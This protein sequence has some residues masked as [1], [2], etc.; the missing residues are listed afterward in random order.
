MSERKYLVSGQQVEIERRLDEGFLV[1]KIFVVESMEFDDEEYPSEEVFLVDKVF[2]KAP[3]EK[4]GKSVTELKEQI[5]ELHLTKN[6]ITKE[7]AVFQSEEKSRLD[8]IKQHKQLDRLEDFIDGKI[9]HYVLH[10]YTPE[11]VALED[12][13]AEYARKCGALR[14][15]VLFGESNGQLNWQLNRYA[16]GSGD[17]IDAVPCCS[18]EEAIQELKK[19]LDFQI[20][21][22][23]NP[24]NLNRY[25][26]AEEKHNIP[27]DSSV[28]KN[29]ESALEAQK[30][31]K[32]TKLKEDIAKLEAPNE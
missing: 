32:I 7:L 11:I 29:Y 1:R 22:C 10:R 14:L 17:M 8:K 13:K 28:V 16:D 21:E 12:T 23:Q 6:N 4:L 25:I 27:L 26:E 15:L 31:T 18:Y 20:S 3:T 19:H 5:A 2:N 24:I 9:T 30:E